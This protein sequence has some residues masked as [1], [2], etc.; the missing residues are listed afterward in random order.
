M[1]RF[2]VVLGLI[3]GFICKRSEALEQVPEDHAM[4]LGLCEEDTLL[5]SF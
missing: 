3:P 1:L 5:L 2:F 4:N